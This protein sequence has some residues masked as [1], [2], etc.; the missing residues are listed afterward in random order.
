MSNDAVQTSPKKRVPAILAAILTIIFFGLAVRRLDLTDSSFLTSLEWRWVD[1]KFRVRGA[2]VPGKEV[3]IVGLDD[4]TLEK[5]GS[6]RVFRRDNFA[7]LVDKLTQAGPKAIGF[8]IN[9]PEKEDINDSTNDLKF[10]QA[11]EASQR[12]VLGIWLN[13][14]PR[15]GPKRSNEALDAEMQKFIDQREVFAAQYLPNGSREPSNFF[16]GKDRKNNIR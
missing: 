8:D 5:L 10:A 3:V 9:F 14:E 16:L 11:V 12:V 7:K 2:R 6:A 15:M 1:L 4:K 13:L